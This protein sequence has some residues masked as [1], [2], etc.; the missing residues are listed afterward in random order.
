[1]PSGAAL[2]PNMSPVPGSQLLQLSAAGPRLVQQQLHCLCLQRGLC[3]WQCCTTWQLPA[4]IWCYTESG[5]RSQVVKACTH[6]Q[7]VHL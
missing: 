5:A 4:W 3:D 1:M 7:A 6:T 2:P